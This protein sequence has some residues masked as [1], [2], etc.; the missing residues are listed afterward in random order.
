MNLTVH[1]QSENIIFSLRNVNELYLAENILSK[2]ARVYKSR[3]LKS[4]KKQYTQLDF[5]IH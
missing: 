3:E 2:K 4:D 5:G 1:D